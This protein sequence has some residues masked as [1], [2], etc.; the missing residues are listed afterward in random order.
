MPSKNLTDSFFTLRNTDGTATMK[1]G[2]GNFN[3][4]EAQTLE[5]TPN[6]GRIKPHNDGATVKRGDDQPMAVSFDIVFEEYVSDSGYSPAELLHSNFRASADDTCGPSSVDIILDTTA[7]CSVGANETLT[8]RRFRW[9]SLSYD[10]DQG[11]ISCS[12]NCLAP[13]P[14][15][16]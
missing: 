7:N 11:Q 9:E 10:I 8:F 14:E 13:A 1:V 5:Y 15:K 16:S 3:W 12:G 2:T 4:T 6:R